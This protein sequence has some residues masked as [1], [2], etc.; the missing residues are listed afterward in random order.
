MCWRV[1]TRCDSPNDDQ[2]LLAPVG[3][4]VGSDVELAVAEVVD[5]QHLADQALRLLARERHHAG[6]EGV[7]IDQVTELGQVDTVAQMADH[8]GEDVAPGERG[9]VGL[10]VVLLVG[11]DHRTPCAACHRHRRGQQP[12]VGPDE[13]ALAVGDLDRDR[14]AAAADTRVDHGEDHPT[15]EVRNATGQRQ[16]AGAHVERCDLVRQVDRVRMRCD[17]VDDR[18]DHTDELV[19]Q[20]VVG[21]QRDGVVAAAHGRST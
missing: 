21:Q 3:D 9:A 6:K 1:A 20:A 8:R 12:V 11:Q 5:P 7:G 2:H 4:L 15:R 18:L 14:L 10:Q 19:D 13:H 17:V 16:A